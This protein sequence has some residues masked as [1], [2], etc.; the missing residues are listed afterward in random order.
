VTNPNRTGKPAPEQT[1]AGFFS[2]PAATAWLNNPTREDR[3]A[4]IAQEL[5]EEPEWNGPPYEGNE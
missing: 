1:G 4:S 5:A 3:R 2:A